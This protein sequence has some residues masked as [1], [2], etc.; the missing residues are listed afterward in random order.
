MKE[1]L[2]AKL[3]GVNQ[4]FKI[5]PIRINQSQKISKKQ[6]PTLLPRKK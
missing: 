2:A 3:R 5:T 4:K 6:Q 1:G